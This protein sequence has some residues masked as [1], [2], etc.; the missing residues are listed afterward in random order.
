[1]SALNDLLSIKGLLQGLITLSIGALISIKAFNLQIGH[2][3]M[4]EGDDNVVSFIEN[5]FY[6]DNEYRL[7]FTFRLLVI[8]L[9]AICVML[10]GLAG[11]LVFE[12]FLLSILLVFVALGGVL[13]SPQ[14]ARA[15]LYSLATLLISYF[16]WENYASMQAA[17]YLAPLLSP[18]WADFTSGRHQLGEIG[19]YA[20][21][22]AGTLLAV[23]GVSYLVLL[24]IQT[25]FSFLID[26]G[27]FDD[28]LKF[29]VF[30]VGLAFV[31][32]LFSSGVVVAAGAPK[33]LWPE[34]RSDVD[35]GSLLAL[36]EINNVVPWNLLSLFG[37]AR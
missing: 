3:V 10:P 23:G 21:V 20:A 1:V 14:P 31:M 6:H 27:R 17:G 13:A 37:L 18:T 5:N 12:A 34:A 28:A 2:R 11:Y 4:I 30:N 22:L 7:S 24:Q 26:R 35:Y 16:V 15:V 36:Q 25:A 8:A 19:G 9:V 29:S 32:I 33:A